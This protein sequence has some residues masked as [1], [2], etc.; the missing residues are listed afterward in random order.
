MS[1]LAAISAVLSVG[2]ITY[3]SRAGLIVFLAD[4]PLP[5]NI[6]RAL[7]YVGPAV[8]SALTVNLIAGGEGVDGVEWVE[9]AAIGVA[10]AVA[11]VAHN[12]I[13]A[14]IAGMVTLWLLLWLL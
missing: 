8:L 7:R 14:L 1:T 4:R 5:V 12:L 6:T 9:V 3:A 13:A 2:L 11:A 10:I